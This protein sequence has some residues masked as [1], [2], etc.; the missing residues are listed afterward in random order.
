VFSSF[1]D[2]FLVISWGIMDLYPLIVSR[3]V[4]FIFVCLFLLSY[5]KFV[6]GDEEC[7]ILVDLLVD[8]IELPL[9]YNHEI[10]RCR[11]FFDR[12]DGVVFFLNT[13]CVAYISFVLLF[14]QV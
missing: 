10:V 9:S 3:R 8:N 7:F 13:V 4:F 12:L 11:F 6:T 2:Y 1:M 5:S 14:I